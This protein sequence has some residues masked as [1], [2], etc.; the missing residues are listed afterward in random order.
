MVFIGYLTYHEK[1]YI[2]HDKQIPPILMM[3]I[4]KHISNLM[5]SLCRVQKSFMKTYIKDM[6]EKMIAGVDHK[7]L[8]CVLIFFTKYIYIFQINNG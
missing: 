8:Q 4:W 5:D 7:G 6:S 2:I 3:N 1:F